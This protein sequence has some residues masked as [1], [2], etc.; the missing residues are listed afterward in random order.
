MTLTGPRD[1][2]EVEVRNGWRAD[3]SIHQLLDRGTAAF[4]I[5]K[6]TVIDA[7][8]QFLSAKHHRHDGAAQEL[9]RS[10]ADIR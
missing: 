9:I 6:Q 4:G 3:L 1:W 8:F 5:P 10:P 7:S 2:N